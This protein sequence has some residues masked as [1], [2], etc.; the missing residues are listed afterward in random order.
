MKR[1]YKDSE[2]VI[3]NEKFRER[4]RKY[5]RENDLS[6]K[7]FSLLCKVSHSTIDRILYSTQKRKFCFFVIDKIKANL[8]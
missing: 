4:I 5:I 1:N 3:I 7:K 8:K 6:S 2:K